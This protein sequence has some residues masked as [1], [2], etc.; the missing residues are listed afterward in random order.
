MFSVDATFPPITMPASRIA[1]TTTDRT[2]SVPLVFSPATELPP[3]SK[4]PM[5]LI[6]PRMPKAT[7]NA[8]ITPAPIR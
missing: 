4:K 8:P 2:L 6:R 3:V 5:W 1:P 7:R